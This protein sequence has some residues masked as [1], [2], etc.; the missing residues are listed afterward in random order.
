M[1]NDELSLIS[2]KLWVMGEFGSIQTLSRDKA[3]WSYSNGIFMSK[4]TSLIAHNCL[5]ATAKLCPSNLWKVILMP[6]WLLLCA[7]NTAI[8]R[9]CVLQDTCLSC[10]FLLYDSFSYLHVQAV[11][12]DAKHDSSKLLPHAH[13]NNEDSKCAHVEFDYL[14]Q[15]DLESS[16]YATPIVHQF[17]Q[18]GKNQVK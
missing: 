9:R 1:L 17:H 2:E 8:H 14:W 12:V 15:S 5:K 10:L 11:V 6:W 18:N 3:K 13:A 4:N 16:V 7:T